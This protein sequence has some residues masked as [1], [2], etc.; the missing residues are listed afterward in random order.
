MDAYVEEENR[1]RLAPGSPRSFKT[2]LFALGCLICSL[3]GLPEAELEMI[4]RVE[5]VPL[6]ID[7]SF[8]L[9]WCL[10]C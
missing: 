10:Q 6:P 4:S 1:Y 8:P 2:D 3:L 9:A 5:V 7:K